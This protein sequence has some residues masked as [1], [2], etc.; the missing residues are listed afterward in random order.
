MPSYSE[1]AT[2]FGVVSKDSAYRIMKK[3]IDQGVVKK[4]A[5]GKLIPHALQ[6]GVAM[7]GLV[8][9]GFPTPAEENL[10]DRVTLDS[11]MIEHPETSFMLRVKGD[12]MIDAGIHEGDFVIVERAREARPGSIVIAEVD[13]GWTMKYLRKKGNLLYLEA[14]NSEYA[15]IIPKDSLSIAAVVVGVVRKYG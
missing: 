4:D 12:S 5:A 8:E 14:G 11:Y 13:G 3:L 1:A 7:L 15:P 6:N 9:A 2:L 10:L